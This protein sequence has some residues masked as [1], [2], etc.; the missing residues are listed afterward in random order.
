LLRRVLWVDGLVDPHRLRQLG[1][2]R[3]LADEPLGMGGIGAVEHVGAGAGDGFGAT[4]VHIGWGEQRDPAVVVLVVI[5]AEEVLA[6]GAGVVDR[7]EPGGEGRV[8]FEGLELAFAVGIVV[9]TWGRECA[10]ECERVTPR[11]ASN[12]ATGLEVILEVI[13][14]PRSAWMASWPAWMPWAAMVSASSRSARA[15]AWRVATIQ[16]GTYRE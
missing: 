8:V 16:P 3:W 13:E 14:V 11:S 1:R 2:L 6:E 15:A 12:M 5:P 9:G 4:L 7:A 10:R